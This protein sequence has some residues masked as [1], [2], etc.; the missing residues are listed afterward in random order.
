M[1]IATWG[2]VYSYSCIFTSRFVLI[3]LFAV[4]IIIIV[5]SIVYIYVLIG[6]FPLHF[7]VDIQYLYRLVMVAV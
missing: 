7:N 6:I 3:S 5:T 2:S 1:Y 4:I